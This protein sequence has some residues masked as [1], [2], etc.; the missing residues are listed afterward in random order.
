VGGQAATTLDVNRASV[1]DRKVVIPI[2]LIVVFVILGLLLRA[3]VA[4]VVLIATVLLSFLTA[5]GASALIFDAVGM[6]ASDPSF[7]LFAFIFLVALGIDYNIF[8]MSRV[9]EES[10]RLGTRR[11]VARGLMT[12][13]GVIT[14]AGVV[15]A[16]TFSVLCVLPIVPLIQVGIAVAVGVLL[17]TFVVRS[18]LVPALTIDIGR[19]VWWP[20]RLAKSAR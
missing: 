18:L 4:P 11:G 9:R 12:T 15:L 13:G 3:L 5:L 17:D 6:H 8:L 10:E 14:S 2:V 7:P 16:A 20:S 1:H 19:R